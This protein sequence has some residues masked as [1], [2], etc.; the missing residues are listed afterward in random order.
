RVVQKIYFSDVETS[1]G[2]LAKAAFVSRASSFE[3]GYT[4]HEDL[5]AQKTYSAI[6]WRHKNT[7]FILNAA[8]S[9]SIIDINGVDT[10]GFGLD[11]FEVSVG[12]YVGETTTVSLQ[13]S[14]AEDKQNSDLVED[15]YSL[16][17][18]HVGITDISF[19]VEG[20]ISMADMLTDDEQFGLALS[21]TL[22]P[23]SKLG[24]GAG[25]D[26]ALA[27]VDDDR[28]FAFAEWFFKPNVRGSATYYISDQD[29]IDVTG[30]SLELSLR[31]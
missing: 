19:A 8:Y 22:Y 13:Y 4:E 26:I 5:D 7:G 23:S 20:S 18:S 1:V 30:L 6:D 3:L 21:A 9:S 25:F 17:I 10:D 31:L 11:Q 27:D 14:R 29:N 2:P 15:A 24:I 12:K 28:V 16:S